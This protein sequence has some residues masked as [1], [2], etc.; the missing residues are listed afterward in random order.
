MTTSQVLLG[1]GLIVVLAVGSQVVAS[2]LRVPAVV[3]LL[4]A[5]FAAGALFSDVDPDRILGHAFEPIISLAVAAI[6]YNAGLR[7]SFRRASGYPRQAALRLVVVGALLTAVLC[8]ITAALVIGLPAGAA[9]L[10][11][12]VLMASGPSVIRPLL[13]VVRPTERLRRLLAWEAALLAPLGGMLAVFIYY[14]V[15]ASETRQGI[16][17]QVGHFLLSAVVGIGGGAAGTAVAWATLR[18]LQV[19]PTLTASVQLALVVGVAAGCDALRPG[20][21]LLAAAIM[22]LALANLPGFRIP[23]RRF[24]ETLIDLILGVLLLS[25]AAAVTPAALGQVALPTLGLVAVLVLVIRPLTALIAISPRD[26][27]RR[28]RLFVGW[29]APRGV[30]AVALA[31]AFASPLAGRSIPG[32]GKIL[33]VALLTTVATVAL[34]GLTAVP[35]SRWLGVLRS[36]CSRPLLVGGERWAI[37]LGQALQTAGLDVLM[38]A[39]LEPQRE[40]I[41]EAA[42]PLAPDSLLAW[43]TTERAELSNVTAILLLTS[44]DDFN[45]LAAA[46]LR[47]SVGDQ[48]YRV[49]PPAIGRGVVAPFTGGTVLF[50]SAL[51]RSTLASR[52]ESGAKIVTQPAECPVPAGYELLFVVH[53]DGRLDPA[54]RRDTPAAQPGD[55]MVLLTPSEDGAEADLFGFGRS[56]TAETWA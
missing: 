2:R 50:G 39:G 41:R 28:D 31:A 34:Y 17:G 21:G 19:A 43:V 38:W 44:E 23:A 55:T 36:P 45:A 49:G 32:A 11:G 35:A 18:K 56:G 22:G 15:I 10:T 26:L 13:T 8:A 27:T 12:A 1:T 54:T 33:P 14:G 37:E 46:V 4:P 48:V 30:M 16:A 40:R 47:Y 29:M 7:V 6:L 53:A 5:G 24:V 9:V 52:Y 3:V 42:L 20:A 51:N 25:A